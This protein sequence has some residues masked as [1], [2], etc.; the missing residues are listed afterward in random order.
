MEDLTKILKEA[1]KDHTEYLR[2]FI[3]A[4][5]N[6]RKEL[7]IRLGRIVSKED[8]NRMKLDTVAPVV[9]KNIPA[10]YRFESAV[11]LAD[12]NSLKRLLSSFKSETKN[13][14]VIINED[15]RETYENGE[16][17]KVEK[18]TRSEKLDIY[19]PGKKYDVRLVLNE[20]K[21]VFKRASKKKAI[22]KRTRRRETY[23]IEPYGFDFTEAILSGERE[24]KR[25]FEVEV[26]VFSSEKLVSSDFVSLIYNFNVD[27]LV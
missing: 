8:G 9:F 19:I 13:D 20:E 24:E 12:F 17:K 15:G 16:L 1:V 25:K 21:E 26:E 11:D 18:K 23:F 27:S 2:K 5:K 3:L 10:E 4:F 6:D 7:E 14:V 22:M